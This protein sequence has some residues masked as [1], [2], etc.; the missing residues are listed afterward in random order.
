M[1]NKGQKARPSGPPGGASLL[2]NRNGVRPR[3]AAPKGESKPEQP[4][5]WLVGGK[6]RRSTEAGVLSGGVSPL[7]G[8]GNIYMIVCVCDVH[9]DKWLTKAKRRAR[10]LCA[11]MGWCRKGTQ[12]LRRAGGARCARRRATRRGSRKTRT[13]N[14]KPES[15]SP[16]RE[17]AADRV[18]IVKRHRPST[19]LETGNRHSHR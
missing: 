15:V 6:R 16:G 3:Y 17:A 7:A 9:I 2:V 4:H 18:A 5:L 13:T 8:C 11:R 12:P 19:L 1:Y 14:E 10:V